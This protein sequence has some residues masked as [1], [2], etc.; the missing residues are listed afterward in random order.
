MSYRVLMLKSAREELLTLYHDY[1]V[2]NFG[3]EVAQEKYQLIKNT[4]DLLKTSPRTGR[5]VPEL[6]ETGF[7]HFRQLVIDGLSKIVYQIDDEKRVI[8]IHVFCATRQDFETVLR[9][10]LLRSSR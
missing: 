9:H 4:I 3:K 6:A 10:R 7:E 2:P 1:L 8:Y 5:S